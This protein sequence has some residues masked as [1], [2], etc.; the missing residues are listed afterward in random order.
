MKP[1]ALRQLF[2][3]VLNVD[4]ASLDDDTCPENTPAWDSV[5][6]LKLA[7]AIEEAFQI[8]LSTREIV[9]MRS[10]GIARG[11]LRKKGVDV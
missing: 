7:A 10:I 6:A 11:V 3:D 1:D 2:A 8:P 9:K 4:A 5:H